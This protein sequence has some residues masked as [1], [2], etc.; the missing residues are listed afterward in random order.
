MPEIKTKEEILHEWNVNVSKQSGY[1]FAST[2]ERFF[3][4]MDEYYNQ[5]IDDAIAKIR[6]R[7]GV[8]FG[9]P[10]HEILSQTI[11][12]LESLKKKP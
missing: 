5:A 1:V 2:V 8:I 3:W 9:S 12:Q 7:P 6:T 4:A 11:N 10:E